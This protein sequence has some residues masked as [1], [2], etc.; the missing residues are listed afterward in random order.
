MKSIASTLIICQFFTLIGQPAIYEKIYDA[1]SDQ[2]AREIIEVSSGGYLIAAMNEK[3][4]IDT[5]VYILRTNV[6]GDTIWTKSFGGNLSEYPN[7]VLETNGGNFLIVGYTYSFGSGN[8]DI[9]LI[10]IDL[11]GNLIWTKTYG[12]SGDDEGKDIIKTSDGNY[13]LTGR[14]NSSGNQYYDALLI[15]IDSDG[16]ILW[17]NNY[18]GNQY[19][20]SRSV[21]QCQDGGFLITGQTLS[22]GTVNGDVY[23]VK[24]DSVGNFLWS[25]TYGGNFIDDGNVVIENNDG[26]IMIAAETNSF[27]AGNMDVWIIKTDSIG[28]MI[29]NQTYGGTAKDVSKTMRKTTD[30]NYLIGAISRSFGWLNPEMWIL[31]I[32]GNGLVA[33]TRRFGSWDHEHCHSARETSNGDFISVGHTRSYGPNVKI[34]LV[35]FDQITTD[36]TYVNNI[37]KEI[38]L[39]PN[40]GTENITLEFPEHLETKLTVSFFSL[41]YKLISKYEIEA[42]TYLIKI[43]LPI[44]QMQNG[45]YLAEINAGN[46]VYKKRFFKN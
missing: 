4:S 14:S 30:G 13:I 1:Q 18:G 20:T 24:T 43:N 12:G 25:K 5:D 26:T 27:G 45:I 11:N 8:K 36:Q 42:Q 41:D 10:K 19:E 22:F 28:N 29:W 40:P 38:K 16:N 17:Q 32:N 2:S 21:W 39:Y 44:Q 46:S 15:K 7:M 9:W 37:S 34:M 6:L 31:K 23:L 35:K 3:T 33:W